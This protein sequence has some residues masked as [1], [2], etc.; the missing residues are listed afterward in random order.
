M[1]IPGLTTFMKTH[2]KHWKTVTLRSATPQG[3][4]KLIVDGGSLL[5]CVNVDGSYGGQYLQFKQSIIHFFS[6]LKGEGISPIVVMDGTDIGSQKFEE[7]LQRRRSKVGPIRKLHESMLQA[8][9]L[10]RL[11]RQ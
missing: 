1:G 4:G 3:S 2:F 5:W 6:Q 8:L 7:R 9:H 11:L 10:K